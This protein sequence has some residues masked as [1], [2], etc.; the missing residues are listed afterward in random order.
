MVCGT[1]APARV[2]RRRPSERLEHYAALECPSG[3]TAFHSKIR[4]VNCLAGLEQPLETGEDSKA[5]LEIIF[6][7]YESAGMGRKVTLPF[8]P[9]ERKK[10]VELW[11]GR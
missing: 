7:A 4:F 8:T 6:A 1:C 3:T 11:L 2:A 10:P 9:P 5:A